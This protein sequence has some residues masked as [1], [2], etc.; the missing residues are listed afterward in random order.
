MKCS[1]HTD[2]FFPARKPE[3]LQKASF[4]KRPES[5]QNEY[6]TVHPRAGQEHSYG[7]MRS[8]DPP[9][10]DYLQPN[11]SAI[12]SRNIDN[13]D[14]LVEADDNI[15]SG[16]NSGGSNTAPAPENDYDY[17]HIE[18]TDCGQSANYEL[19]KAVPNSDYEKCGQSKSRTSTLTSHDY[20]NTPDS[21]MGPPKV[22][23]KTDT[24]VTDS[25]D[26]NLNEV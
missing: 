25:T 8:S 12:R 26:E 19:A 6:D 11:P 4:W 24:C 7:Y 9:A 14:Y 13:I 1:L 5:V 15:I 22:R 20:Y 23:E 21:N 2:M 16:I 18:D 3:L 10:G 17:I